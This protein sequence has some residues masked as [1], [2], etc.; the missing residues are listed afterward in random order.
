MVDL[1]KSHLMQF[2]HL[3]LFVFVYPL[4]LR[5]IERMRMAECV[6][7]RIHS[8]ILLVHFCIEVKSK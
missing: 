2:F 5:K 7:A 4:M 3:L 1:T 6:A 8:E